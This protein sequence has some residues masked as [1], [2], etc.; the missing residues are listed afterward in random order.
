MVS[1]KSIRVCRQQCTRL[2]VTLA[3]K[4]SMFSQLEWFPNHE[5]SQSNYIW[6][7][8]AYP[9]PARGRM[10]CI[11]KCLHRLQM[12]H[13]WLH[14][15]GKH[16]SIIPS[17]RSRITGVHLHSSTFAKSNCPAAWRSL[18]R[19]V[20]RVTRVFSFSTWGRIAWHQISS[21]CCTI[22]LQSC[23][24]VNRLCSVMLLVCAPCGVSRPGAVRSSGFGHVCQVI[25]NHM[26]VSND[27]VSVLWNRTLLKVS[28]HPIMLSFLNNR[29][30]RLAADSLFL[31]Q[32]DHS[33]KIGVRR[34]RKVLLAWFSTN[35]A[36]TFT[37]KQ[38]ANGC[39][40]MSLKG[41]SSTY[42]VVETKMF[43]HVRYLGHDVPVASC[44]VMSPYLACWGPVPMLC[45]FNCL[46]SLLN[47]VC[48]ISAWM[49]CVLLQPIPSQPVQDTQEG[50]T[51]SW[52]QPR[53]WYHLN[54]VFFASQPG[55]PS[56]SPTKP[57][58]RNCQT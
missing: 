42:V 41:R 51:W 6:R 10:S 54:N 18:I 20:A 26:C 35:A 36:D 23:C 38:D 25:S 50:K 5:M 29:V 47:R 40:V 39:C 37:N 21:C 3:N 58:L 34:T 30:S 12:T 8:G 24:R 11:R 14:W 53:S 2:P 15:M 44:P 1:N 17:P 57:C 46:I 56:F 4:M 28:Q 22:Q 31:H 43:W 16:R 49:T 33:H 27:N 19:P 52:F 55:C 7:N 13:P 45:V 32:P 9:F 48:G